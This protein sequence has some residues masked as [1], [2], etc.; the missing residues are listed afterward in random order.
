MGGTCY[1]YTYVILIEAGILINK[2]IKEALQMK[3]RVLYRNAV[4]AIKIL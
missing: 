4:F 1:V 3:A 2:K